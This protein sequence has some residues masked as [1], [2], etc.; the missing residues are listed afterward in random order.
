MPSSPEVSPSPGGHSR[1]G[2]DGEEIRG[3]E[4]SVTGIGPLE[5]FPDNRCE[6]WPSQGTGFLT[7]YLGRRRPA[8]A[9]AAP[10]RFLCSFV[11]SLSVSLSSRLPQSQGTLA[12]R[13]CTALSERK[14][15]PCRTHVVQRD[16]GTG[17]P[18]ARPHRAVAGHYPPPTPITPPGMR[19]QP[20]HAAVTREGGSLSRAV[21]TSWDRSTPLG[22]ERRA[23]RAL[24]A[25]KQ[26]AW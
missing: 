23:W 24:T 13:C 17:N 10:L 18:A 7:E 3:G 2:K 8:A 19:S 22:S 26:G 14:G 12:E 4:R 6:A 5:F 11:L 1:A 21:G 9:L 25:T 20:G 15:S 16:H